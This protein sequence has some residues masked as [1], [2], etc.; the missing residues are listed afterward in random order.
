MN[1]GLPPLKEFILPGGTRAA[2][3]AHVARTLA[4]APSARWCIWAATRKC[5]SRCASTSIAVRISLFIIGPRAEPRRRQPGRALAQGPRTQLK[6]WLLTPPS[7]SSA[8][9]A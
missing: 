3:L 6:A 9:P 8:T 4:A 1:A 2:S 5:A 7:S